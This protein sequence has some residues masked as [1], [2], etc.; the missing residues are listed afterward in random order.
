MG[1]I[2]KGNWS[3]KHIKSF[4]GRGIALSDQSLMSSRIG[5]SA[6]STHKIVRDN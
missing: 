1:D 6:H 2:Q 4:Y 3:G 5:S